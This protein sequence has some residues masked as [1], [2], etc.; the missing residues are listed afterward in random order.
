MSSIQAYMQAHK[1]LRR[2]TGQ[3]ADSGELQT[4]LH[5]RIIDFWHI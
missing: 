5:G 2:N 4:R 3:K 1:C